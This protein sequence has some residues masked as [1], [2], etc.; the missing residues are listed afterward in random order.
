MNRKEL[1][2][3]FIVISNWKNTLFAIVYA[4]IF[5]RCKGWW[6]WCAQST[7]A[8]MSPCACVVY[9]LWLLIYILNILFNYN[10]MN[11]AVD[12]D[13]TVTILHIIACIWYQKSP[14]VHFNLN[15]PWPNCWP[16]CS[17]YRCRLYLNKHWKT[18]QDG[19]TITIIIIPNVKFKRRDNV[20]KMEN[21]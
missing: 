18:T 8:D 11:G 16:K 4:K 13:E 7:F 19:Q 21:L 3:T 2:K 20:L 9:I 14:G 12:S 15:I 17:V 1:T 10:L 6:T 5:Q